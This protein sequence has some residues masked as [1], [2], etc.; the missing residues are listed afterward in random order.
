MQRV[1]MKI[2]KSIINNVLELAHPSRRHGGAKRNVRFLPHITPSPEIP[3]AKNLAIIHASRLM[4]QRS[5]Y[6]V[7]S[8]LKRRINCLL[9]PLLPQE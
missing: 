3:A 6:K 7:G 9:S 4:I 8:M 5:L 1:N 2:S